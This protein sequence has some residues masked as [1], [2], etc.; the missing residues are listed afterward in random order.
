MKIKAYV[1]F[2]LAVLMCMSLLA[3][4]PIENPGTNS[5]QTTTTNGD[6]QNPGNDNQTP[7][8]S[9][10]EPPAETGEVKIKF[11]KVGKSPCTIIRTE[12][13]T[14]VIDAASEDQ[15]SD[16]VTYLNEKKVTTVD[17]LIITNFSKS[18]I[19]GVPTLLRAEGITVKEIYEPAYPKESSAYTSYKNAV[20]AAALTP[21]KITEG[22]SIEADELKI[23][24]FT[25]QKQYGSMADE[26]DEGNSV[27][28]SIVHNDVKFLYTSRIAGD[29][30]NEVISQ[31][32]DNKYNLITVPN[33]G[34]Y[35]AKYDA[36]FTAT[37]AKNAVIFASTK[38]P[39][40]VGTTGALDSA[41]ISYLVTR[42]GGI[43]A[44]SNGTELTIKQ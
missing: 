42:D 38:N 11:L 25:P 37:G 27:A 31:I 7:G 21:K 26:N 41:K 35:D 15:G 17:Y 1:A 9:D 18:C 12:N 6:N 16:L 29:R 34:I 36:L 28:L 22:L 33:Y 39:P 8:N 13:K 32:G 5:N 40:E 10:D 20:A 19:G 24:C 30:V 4:A 23:T 14:I 44:R 3:C 43:E 2:V